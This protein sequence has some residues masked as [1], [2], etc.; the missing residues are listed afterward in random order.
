MITGYIYMIIDWYL[1]NFDNDSL[2]DFCDVLSVCMC[3]GAFGT[4]LMFQVFVDT[5]TYIYNIAMMI[6]YHN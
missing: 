4:R 6:L 1:Y 5:H 3:G 2:F